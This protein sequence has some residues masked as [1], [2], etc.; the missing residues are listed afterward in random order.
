MRRILVMDDDAELRE[1]VQEV[2]TDEGFDI[3]LASTFQQA[4]AA[5]AHRSFDLIVSDLLVDGTSGSRFEGIHALVRA[6]PETPL[7]VSTG[8]TEAKDLP[9]KELGVSGLIPK[10]FELDDLIASIRTWLPA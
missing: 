9:L 6:A 8:F 5:L 7:L 10:P 2:L 4:L 1:V 3:E